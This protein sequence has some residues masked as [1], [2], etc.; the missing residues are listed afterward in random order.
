MWGRDESQM[1]RRC[2]LYTQELTSDIWYFLSLPIPLR[3]IL[4]MSLPCSV[5]RKVHKLALPSFLAKSGLPMHLSHLFHGMKHWE[6]GG[7]FF[8]PLASTFQFSCSSTVN[9]FLLQ[10]NSLL[11]GSSLKLLL[12]LGSGN[13]IFFLYSGLGGAK[14]SSVLFSSTPISHLSTTNFIHTSVKFTFS[15]LFLKFLLNP[16]NCSIKGRMSTIGM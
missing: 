8:P 13:S 4:C 9:C 14:A 10:L 2:K 16:V 1:Q 12:S 3:C 5:P 11:D 6:N 7:R 15:K